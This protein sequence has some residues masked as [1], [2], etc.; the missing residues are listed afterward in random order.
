[1]TEQPRG[2]DD[3]LRVKHVCKAFGA[4][5]ALRDVSFELRRGSIHAL[6]GGNGSGKSTLIKTLAGVQQADE[7]HAEID[8]VEYDLRSL[9]PGDARAAGLHFVHQQRSTFADLTVAE[10]LG[11]GHGFETTFGFRIPWRRTRG[12]AAEVLA[13][14]EIDA[15]PDQPLG[16]L[17]PATQTMVAIAR[18]LQDQEDA[19]DGILLLDEPTASLPAAEVEGLLDALRRYAA[20]GQT[21][22]YVTHRL[23]EVF[24]IAD[25]ATLLRDGELVD[26]VEPR[27]LDHD[28]LIELMMGKAV[29]R[30]QRARKHGGGG[31]VVLELRGL[32]GGALEPTNLTTHAGEIVGI[33]GLLGSGRS[34]LLKT[35]FGVIPARGGELLLDGHPHRV[36]R[37]YEAMRAGIAYVPED[38]AGD[39]AFNELTV[40]E[41]LSITV[42]ERFWKRGH[43]S[44]R[45]ASRNA[46]ELLDSFLI[47]AASEIAPLSSLSGGNQQKVIL[48]RWLQR[49]PRV[50]LLDEPTQGVDVRARAE[51]YELIDRA[52][53][54]G[55]TALVVSSDF[56]ELAA[57]CDRALIFR[58]GRLVS[59]LTSSDIDADQLN[60]LVQAGGTT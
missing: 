27:T 51:I 44:G 24:A 57:I 42:L 55:A 28:R 6:L 4:T 30:A 52:T 48:A 8:G 60:R 43:L 5:R 39:A 41:N 13:R 1:M 47:T 37:P 38:R 35:L 29:A 34:S 15:H 21:I 23:D 53:A 7:G 25:R 18:A 59:D 19:S 14:F 12:R 32:S 10:N 54:A 56:E 33:G 50:L 9:T 45:A 22:L 49:N 40:E 31:G 11:I 3:A 26:T 36:T 58:R 2:A 17:R 46:N 20:A 16:E